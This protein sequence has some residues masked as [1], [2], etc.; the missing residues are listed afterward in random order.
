MSRI[1]GSGVVRSDVDGI[2]E[3]YGNSQSV[4]LLVHG[5]YETVLTTDLLP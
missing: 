1:D 3:L 2:P 4:D 5:M